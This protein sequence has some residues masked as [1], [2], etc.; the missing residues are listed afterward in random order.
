M[1]G[2]LRL[3][4]KFLAIYWL[5]REEGFINYGVENV[6]QVTHDRNLSFD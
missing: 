5:N 1:L 6:L 2:A 4:I 3:E